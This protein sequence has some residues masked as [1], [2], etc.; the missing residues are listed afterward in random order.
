MAPRVGLMR[1]LGM[2]TRSAAA[3]L[4]PEMWESK[5][6]STAAT[7]PGPLLRL[8]LLS[9]TPFPCLH[10]TNSCSSFKTYPSGSLPLTSRLS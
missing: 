1:Q 2:W 3:G 10:L 9:D 4:G 7:A 6:E 8:C 5:G